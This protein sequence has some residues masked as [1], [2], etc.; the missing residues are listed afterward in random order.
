VSAGDSYYGQPV[1]KEPT[2]T[3]EIPFYF[4]TGGLAG[5]SAGL[6]YLSELNGDDVLARRAWAGS[7]AA[8][9]LSP[10]FLISDLGKPQR[11]FNMLR[12]FKVT[13]PMNM[14]SW[15]LTASGLT[16][17]VATASEWTGT[18]PRAARFAK[19]AAALLGLPLSTYTAALISNTA[20]PVWQE[21]RRTLPFVFASGAA[22]S[23]GAVAVAAT[24]PRH[25]GSARRLAVAGGVAEAVVNEGM[26]HRLGMYGE[27]YKEGSTH[28]YDNISRVCVTAGAA[29]IATRAK[30]SRP[31]AIAG[32]ALL[33]AGA[34]AARWSIFTAGFRSAADPK[35]VVKP[36]R[37]RIERGDARGGA[38]TVPRVAAPDWAVATPTTADA[39]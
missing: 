29:L 23:A 3:W 36:Q 6:A 37:E 10:L 25:A 31:A 21:A 18:F 39:D 28:V 22:A 27:V 8:V 15:I 14:G 35:Y 5:A 9:G 12:V 32:G 7:L 2:W 11:F 17:A 34:L 33:A 20:V 24:P 30:D 19:P 13:S 26:R 38:R 16:T 1:I 4:F